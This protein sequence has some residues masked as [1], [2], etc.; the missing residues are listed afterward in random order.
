MNNNNEASQFEFLDIITVV[1]FMIQLDDHNQNRVAD[2]DIKEL[3]DKVL[4][5]NNKLDKIL[6]LLEGGNPNAH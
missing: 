2:R 3:E 4:L 5:V 1:S 6:S